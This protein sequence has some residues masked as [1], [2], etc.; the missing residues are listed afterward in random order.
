M[1]KWLGHIMRGNSLL[2]T[3]KRGGKPKARS[4]MILSLREWM[5]REGYSK[6]DKQKN[7]YTRSTTCLKAENQQRGREEVWFLK[8]GAHTQFPFKNGFAHN[9]F[10]SSRIQI[11]SGKMFSTHGKMLHKGDFMRTQTLTN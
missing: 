4:L 11:T 3:F 2:R 1:V 7:S 10:T 5:I 8:L 6:L 9:T